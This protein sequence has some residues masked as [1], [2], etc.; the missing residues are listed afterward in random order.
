MRRSV[1]SRH[2]PRPVRPAPGAAAARSIRELI[3]LIRLPVGSMLSKLCRRHLIRLVVTTS[4]AAN[5]LPTDVA[6]KIESPSKQTS[7]GVPIQN[8]AQI[9][10]AKW[11]R[12]W[13][14]TA[15]CGPGHTVHQFAPS[16][17][18]STAAPSA[19]VKSIHRRSPDAVGRSVSRQRRNVLDRVPAGVPHSGGQGGRRSP[20]ESRYASAPGEFSNVPAADSVTTAPGLHRQ[21]SRRVARNPDVAPLRPHQ[22]HAVSVVVPLVSGNSDVIDVP[23]IGITPA[24]PSSVLAM[25]LPVMLK[26]LVRWSA[27]TE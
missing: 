1:W 6:G 20:G 26:P 13:H 11:V 27:S 14:P 12:E 5:T 25:K 19:S 7:V 9:Y 21:I 3:I 15:V 23:S 2:P 10:R 17:I 4:A 8:S 18:T 22:C 24:A 16:E